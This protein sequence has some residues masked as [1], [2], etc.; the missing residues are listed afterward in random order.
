MIM[1]DINYAITTRHDKF[2]TELQMI[3]ID[4]LIC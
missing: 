2:H 1:D 3:L 4:R